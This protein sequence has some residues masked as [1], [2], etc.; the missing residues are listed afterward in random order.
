V[1]ASYS[2]PLTDVPLLIVKM[3]TGV[4]VSKVYLTNQSQSN[5]IFIGDPAVSA[6]NGFLITKQQASGVSYRMDFELFAGQELYACCRAGQTGSVHV[7][8]SA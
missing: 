1:P 2:L 6:S 4:P 8:F 3:P 5:D 7:G